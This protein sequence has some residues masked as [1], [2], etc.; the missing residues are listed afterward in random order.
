MKTTVND[1]LDAIT[2]YL[3]TIKR[4]TFEGWYE[5]EIGMP[6]NWVFDENEEINCDVLE[7]SEAGKL[8]LISPKNPDVPIDA[9]IT[10]VE[11]IIE[12]NDRIAEKEKEFVDKMLEMKASLEAKAKE[13]YKE[14][15]ELRENSF[16]EKNEAF[17]KTLR[18]VENVKEEKKEKRQYNKKP[19]VFTGS[20][21]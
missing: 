13:F 16:R 10:F 12:T 3:I 15:D 19:V 6:F 21:S 17:T 5:L 14:L 8:V 1:A 7:E 9:L 11:V 4:N 2:G 18:P 20:T